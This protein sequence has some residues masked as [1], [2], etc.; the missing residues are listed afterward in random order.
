MLF[1]LP[2]LAAQTQPDVWKQ[3]NPVY[4]GSRLSSA[5]L[6][7]AQQR[8]IALLILQCCG[9]PSYDLPE[10]KPD[11]LLRCL[12]FENIP[13][14]PKQQ[15]VLIEEGGQCPHGGTGG[16]GDLWLVRFDGNIPTLLA[17]PEDDFSGWLYSVQPTATH[18]YYDLV[19]GWHMGAGEAILTYFQFNGRSYVSVSR[20]ADLCD[21]NGCRIDVNIAPN[22]D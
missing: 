21:Q 11:R 16:G 8:A 18:N 12:I 17:S 2:T 15:V 13:L 5:T 14:T 3:V 22:R 1:F 7:E 20:A 19:L 10:S 6:S 4:H 9:L